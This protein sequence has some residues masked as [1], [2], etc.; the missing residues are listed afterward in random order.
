MILASNPQAAINFSIDAGLGKT[1]HKIK[2]HNNFNEVC[3]NLHKYREKASNSDQI[4]L[5]F[6]ILPGTNDNQVEFDAVIALMHSLGVKLM[7]ISR[8]GRFKYNASNE[9]QQ[10]LINAAKK[11]HS[12]LCDKNMSADLTDF[13]HEEKKLITL[14]S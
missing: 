6:I 14:P 9:Y 5:K 11:F 3:H 4:T 12:M 2:G 1:W 13:S 7:W 10:R 8:D